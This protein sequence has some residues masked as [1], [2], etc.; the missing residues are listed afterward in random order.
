MQMVQRAAH[1]GTYQ[2]DMNMISGLSKQFYRNL[3]LDEDA[4][5]P[6]GSRIMPR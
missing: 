2:T 5:L 3:G 4:P 6:F 1:I